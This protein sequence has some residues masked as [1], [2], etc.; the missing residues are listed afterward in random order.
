MAKNKV[1]NLQNTNIA[2]IVIPKTLDF[3]FKNFQWGVKQELGFAIRILNV[4][5]V[6][7]CTRTEGT[8]Q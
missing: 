8:I 2:L 4:S 7:N 1:C 5:L 6:G 3:G